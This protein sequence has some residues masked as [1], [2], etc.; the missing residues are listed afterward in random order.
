MQIIQANP[1]EFTMR[2]RAMQE[3]FGQFGESLS[4]VDKGIKE[5]EATKRQQALEIGK[6]RMALQEKGYDTSK[7]SDEHLGANLGLQP[8]KPG[9]LAGL[10]GG[11]SSEAPVEKVNVFKERTQEWK[12][13]NTKELA[14]KDL[15]RRY[16]ESQI[17]KNYNPK[18]GKNNAPVLKP[19]ELAK[20]NEGNQ[21]PSVL[22]DLKVTLEQNKDIFGPVAG[23]ISSLNPYDE[24]GKTADAQFQAAA[25]TIGKYLEGGVLRAED[26]PKYRKMLPDLTDTPEIA[27]NK[28]ATVERLLV[29]K[30]NS[31]LAALKGAGYDTSSIDRGLVAPEMPGVLAGNGRG[32]INQATASVIKDPARTAARQARIQELRA[33]AG[34][35]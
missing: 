26:I 9:G 10:F 16:K 8:I 3:G 23:R 30:Q 2:Q 34:A 20:F 1:S 29:Q 14:E 32:V 19:N 6:T 15:D 12:D 18:G 21:M 25:Q 5:F 13:K 4:R 33:K 24:K 11:N 27:A 31:D 7:I 22:S 35:R 28:L 17:Y